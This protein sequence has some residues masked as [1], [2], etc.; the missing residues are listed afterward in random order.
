MIRWKYWHACW[1]IIIQSFRWY[2]VIPSAWWM[3]WHRNYRGAAMQ[4][5]EFMAI[6]NRCSVTEW[7]KNSEMGKQISW[8]QPMSQRVELMWMMLK[9][10]STMICHR[11]MNIMCTG[12]EEL[13]A[14][15]VPEKRLISL[16]ARKYTN[17]KRSSAIARQ[18]SRRSQS[19]L[20][21]MWQRSRQIRFLTGSD[22]LSRTE[23][24]AIWSNWLSSRW[25][26]L[27][28]PRWILQLRF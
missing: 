17:S 16:R 13:D 10:Y 25:T 24:C 5:R 19:H 9:Q 12:S 26:T 4:Q 27:I 15:A 14:P 11:T 6:W 2:F 7:W 22:R 28:I 3:N 18:R 8:L 23:I 21:M 20:R 1:I